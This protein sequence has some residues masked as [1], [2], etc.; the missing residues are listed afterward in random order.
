MRVLSAL[1]ITLLSVSTVP[2]HAEDWAQFRGPN[3]TGVS[4]ESNNLPEKFSLDEKVLWS[5][6]LGEGIGCPIIVGDY[7]YSTA[8]VGEEKFGIFCLNA[9]TGEEVWRREFDTGPLP[10]I[11]KPNT[12]ASSTPACDGKSI[13]VYFSTLGMRAFDCQTGEDIW[14]ADVPMPQYLMGWGAAHSHYL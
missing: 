8:M 12:Q 6:E 2:V 10:A 11:M 9:T 5:V 7:A 14:K 1:L 4:T 3:A 13:Y